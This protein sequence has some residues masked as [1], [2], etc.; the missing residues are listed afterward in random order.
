M[1]A[2][3][4]HCV[5]GP[6]ATQSL[7]HIEDAVVAWGVPRSFIEMLSRRSIVFAVGAQ[8]RAAVFQRAHGLA[9]RFLKRAADAP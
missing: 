8:A 1:P 9:E 6:T 2:R 5:N 3:L 7:G 4:V